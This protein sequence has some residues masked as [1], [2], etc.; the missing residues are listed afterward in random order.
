MFWNEAH[1]FIVTLLWE[2]RQSFHSSYP[3]FCLL[4][5]CL[6]VC[7]VLSQYPCPPSSYWAEQLNKLIVD[8]W[9]AQVHLFFFTSDP[10]PSTPQSL[11]STL[12]TGNSNETAVHYQHLLAAFLSPF[13]TP[14]K[15]LISNNTSRLDSLF[16]VGIV[17]YNTRKHC[18]LTISGNGAV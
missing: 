17:E 1:L 13:S 15:K 4:T 16:R 5:L 14:L 10:R 8:P 6:V 3:S 18:E 7:S 12:F 11:L 9:R 2:V